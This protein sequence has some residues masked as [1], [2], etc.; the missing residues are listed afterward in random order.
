MVTTTTSV[1]WTQQL[2]EQ[3][4]WHWERQAR[5]RLEGLGDEEYH[6]APVPEYWDVRRRGTS[7]A[8]V[9]M[10]TGDWTCDFATPE[11]EPAPVT[12]IAWQLAHLIVGV[13]GARVQS[14]FSADFKW[15]EAD[16]G[17]WPYAGTAQG[18]LAQ[19][20]ATY[21]A[22]MDGVRGLSAE[23]LTRQVGPAEGPFAEYSMA[24]LV[25]HISREAIH[26]LSVTATLRDL[27]ANR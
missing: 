17:V 3:L 22:W 24:A 1:D 20:D 23:D 18:G 9:Q 6:W 10:G 13:F 11:P 26:H 7:G 21:T 15:G 4:E 2:V 5:P 27:Y 16:Y 14:H 8:A 12:T 19:L 25:L